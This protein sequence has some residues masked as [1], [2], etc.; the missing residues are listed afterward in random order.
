VPETPLRAAVL[1]AAALLL[2][3]SCAGCGADDRALC[4]ACAAAL[5]PAPRRRVLADGIP[6]YA[7]LDY[8]GIVREVIV[9]M[10]SD[11]PGLAR[12]LAPALVA[13]IGAAVAGAR[14]ADGDGAIEL[15][16]V[17][18]TRRARRRRGYDP[19]RRTLAAGG[20][21]VAPVFRAA[22]PHPTQKTLSRAERAAHLGGVFAARG[23]L[24]GRR[25]VLVDDVVTT[26]ATLAAA[27]GAVR[28]AGGEVLA[29]A[30][31]ASTPRRVPG[32]GGDAATTLRN[33]PGRSGDSGSTAG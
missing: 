11:R 6:A 9:A 12:R 19:V 7:G 20:Y 18:A 28:A 10:K 29:Y 3:V 26:G 5:A 8:D 25:F 15:C 27:A 21:R 23:T 17:P 22:R 2:P 16:A 13:A 33:R 1:D 24:D 30:A 32:F 14:A 4:G 31:I